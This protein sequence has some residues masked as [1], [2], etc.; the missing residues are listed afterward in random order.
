MKRFN[1]AIIKKLFGACLL[2]LLASACSLTNTIEKSFDFT[3][4]TT[5]S[6]WYFPS[7]VQKQQK[8]VYFSRANFNRLKEDMASGQGKYLTSLATLMDVPP[9]QHEQFFAVSKFH[10]YEVFP[11]EHVTP[12]EMLSNLSLAFSTAQRIEGEVVSSK[13]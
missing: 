10:Y 1:G 6:G 4:S 8:I 3:S 2:G 7:E 11:N 5:P 13:G 9:A 12:E